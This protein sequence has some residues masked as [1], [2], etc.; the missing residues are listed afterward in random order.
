MARIPVIEQT[1]SVST[2]TPSAQAQGVQVLSPLGNAGAVAGQ[3]LEELAHA[4]LIE[5]HV[6]QQRQDEQTIANMPTS[7][8]AVHWKQYVTDL[9]KN[10]VDGGN[11]KQDDGTLI[12]LHDKT[13]KDF[14]T[15]SADF[16]SK[17]PE[18]KAKIYAQGFISTLR[19]QT[20][21]HAITLEANANLAN[22]TMKSD[23]DITNWSS[24]AAKTTDL[25]AIDKIITDAK[26]K[27][28]NS[29]FDQFTRNAQALKA[30]QAIVS[31]AF[32]GAMA[33]DPVAAKAALVTRFGIDPTAP[34]PA[35]AAA[36]GATAQPDGSI[37]ASGSV[38]S[39]AIGFTLK[40]EGG[41]NKA[42][43]NGTASN[44][45]INQAAHPEIDVKTLTKE[46][47][48]GIYQ[49]DYWQKI[50]GDA[51]AAKSPGLAIAAMDTAALAG[52]GKAQEL[53]A[54]A[55]GD[56]AKF[57]DLR[58]S[59]LAGLLKSNPA[60]YGAYAGAWSSRNAD[61]RTAISAGG[62]R[63]LINPP[64][65][66]PDAGAA[67]AA[68]LPAPAAPAIS[69]GMQTLV[70]QLP[71]DQ[72]PQYI[73][74]ATTIVNQQQ[75][76]VRSQVQT[77][78]S[79]QTTAFMNGETVAK[80]LTQDDYTKAYGATEG[81]SRYENFKSIQQLGS[82]ISAMKAMPPDQISNM[83]E[84][85]KP[86]PNAP[87]YELAAKRYAAAVQAANQV[88]QARNTDPIAYAQQAGIGNAAPIDWSKPKDAM[89]ELNKRTGLA[90]TLN[91]V[92]QSPYSLLSKDEAGRLSTGMQ[93][94]TTE[95]KLGFL[96]MIATTVSD[97]RAQQAIFQQ[98]APDS[99]VTA[100]AGKLMTI[101]QNAT[102]GKGW[103]SSGTTYDPKAVASMVLQGEAIL[104]PSKATKG[105][106]GKPINLVMPKE[107]DM[108]QDFNNMVGVAYP[109]QQ[110][111]AEIAYGAIRAYYAA[112]SVKAGDYKGMY[113]STRYKEAVDAV[114]GGKSD[115]RGTS[116][117]RPWGMDDGTFKDQAEKAFNT[118]AA[119]LGLKG[120]AANFNHY[121]LENAG[122]GYL[123]R[124]GSG[125]LT[126]DG[127]PVMI[128]VM[129]VSTAGPGRGAI[130]PPQGGPD[131]S[132][133]F[134]PQPAGKIATPVTT[135]PKTK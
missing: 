18:G 82:D 24:L 75:A 11:I 92:Y 61:L 90:A 100:V 65:V 60:K 28:A 26:T 27:I 96:G 9:P 4:G 111:D 43:T 40:H 84:R 124:S 128:N 36:P 69:P 29:G 23:Q 132:G 3:G 38:M 106:D 130:N 47:A 123:M 15:W 121:G 34:P 97:P 53:L 72:V 64:A 78:E 22:K 80:P 73:A 126:V 102:V 66:V 56:A 68:S 2:T 44:F 79:D 81:A 86:D 122:D 109:G 89:A 135:P 10:L 20:L 39:Q 112:A 41:L 129:G 77:T 16:I 91:Q 125:Y 14:D 118:E 133:T 98:I 55:G 6:A 116:F 127:K 114:T 67:P 93:S 107:A 35:P 21:D 19:T 131:Q 83:V 8:A 51:I 87:G 59:F 12:T 25:D 101:A 30:Q 7:D 46:K 105:E 99:P 42:D 54:K 37:P 33:R 104:N 62:G 120:S 48:A 115:Q 45:G 58:E 50:G 110:R 94:M 95:Q 17:V 31:A 74:H 32:Q 1:T 76:L 71:I 88:T 52:V 70:N 49:K 57:M 103:M 119:R 134:V 108:R 13:Q 5:A 113:D 63:G 117:I 85:Y